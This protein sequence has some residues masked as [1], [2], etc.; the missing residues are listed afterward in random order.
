MEAQAVNDRVER[1]S[2]SDKI[3]KKF[4]CGLIAIRRDELSVEIV[5]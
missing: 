5:K 4:V 1:D 2:K 3:Y